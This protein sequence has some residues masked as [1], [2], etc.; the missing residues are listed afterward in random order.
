MLVKTGKI[1]FYTYL[2]T[3]DERN[4]IL[5][6]SENHKVIDSQDNISLNEALNYLKKYEQKNN[7]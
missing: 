3:G 5:E 6:I 1:G 7:H 4:V 2:I